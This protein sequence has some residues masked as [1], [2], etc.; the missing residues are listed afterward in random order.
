MS[1]QGSGRS[2]P[3]GRGDV[4]RFPKACEARGRI[5]LC[6]NH[7]DAWKRSP[8]RATGQAIRV[9]KVIRAAPPRPPQH[10]LAVTMRQMYAA[11]VVTWLGVKNAAAAS[12][13]GRASL[14]EPPVDLVRC[15]VNPATMASGGPTGSIC[16]G[17]PRGLKPAA[18]LAARLMK[19]GTRVASGGYEG[20]P[21]SYRRHGRG[22]ER[23]CDGSMR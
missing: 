9:S 13:R 17:R 15:S 3:R 12:R 23:S 21:A 14:G 19:N 6:R 1:S 11:L 18:R 5:S 16:P 7:E 4:L 8:S 10:D 2:G 22:G 20:R